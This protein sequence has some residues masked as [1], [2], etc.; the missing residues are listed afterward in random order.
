MS[1][2]ATVPLYAVALGKTQ[3][4]IRDDI[5]RTL[6]NHLISI[7]IPN[8]NVGP[9]SDYY[10]IATGVANEIC[11]GIANGIVQTDNQMP[12]TA[13]GTFLDRWLALF[14]LSRAG[15]TQSR[16]VVTPDYSLTQGYTTVPTDAILIDAVGLR[17]QVSVPGQYG[18][19]NP[20]NGQPA[21]M[22]VPVISVD[23]GSATNHDNGDPLT[24]VTFVPFVAEDASVGTPGGEDGLSGGNNSEVGQDQPP[25]QRLFTRMQNPPAG[26][27]WSDVAGWCTES[28]PDVQAGFCYP[29][30]LGPATV[31]FAVCGA[32]Q[33]QAPFSS[34]SKSRELSLALVAGTVLPYVQGKYS[35]RAAV[36]GASCVDEPTDVALLLSL[37]AAPTAAPSGPGGGWLDGSPWP[38][39]VGGTAPCVVTGFV[40]GAVTGTGAT[41][42]AVT[43]SGTPILNPC[44]IIVTV[45][46]TGTNTTATASWSLN[47]VAQTPFTLA[48]SVTLPGTDLTANFPSGTYTSGDFYSSS[49]VANAF[50]C[51]AM[52]APVPGISRIAYVSVGDWNLYV[53]TVLTVSGGPGAYV[54]TTDTPWPNLS[55]DLA[56]IV[57]GG[58]AGP[59]IFPQ[60]VNQLNYLAAALQGFANLGTGEWTTNATALVRA[61]R[62]PVPSQAWPYALDATFLRTVEDS[63][64]EVLAV[65]YLYRSAMIPTVPGTP[66]TPVTITT[67]E[68]LTL[69]SAAP[70]CLTP[71]SLSWYAQ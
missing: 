52:S 59:A 51:D 19:G 64:N 66:A 53:A 57:A 70:N 16:G 3:A 5:L 18:P 36:I 6:S 67:S 42:Q 33:T 41:V 47:G 30:L 50:V 34:T 32:A 65:Q 22:Q 26:G 35:T 4:Q 10:G 54:V 29:A 14:G 20:S 55:E 48:A 15:A 11:V 56:A 38:S 40:Q 1:N 25:R 27:N 13:A 69:T 44:S 43:L 61:F 8:P 62:H 31:F 71:R 45:Q 17:F 7:G 21:R 60:S 24:W 28:S 23:A 58:G 39:S 68:P 2:I 49:S 12:D 37:P 46:A 63:G 9:G